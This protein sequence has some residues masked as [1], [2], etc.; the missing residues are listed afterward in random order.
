MPDP[1]GARIARAMVEL[2]GTRGYEATGLDAVCGRARTRREDF[3]RRFSDKE[4]CFL[5]VHDE[6]AAE[7]CQRVRQAYCGPRGW[8][9]RIW[10]AGWEA[11]G[12]LAEDAA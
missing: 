2:V 11:I 4:E 10:A 7:F 6:I 1:V 12:F 8:R 9:E 5:A 3:D